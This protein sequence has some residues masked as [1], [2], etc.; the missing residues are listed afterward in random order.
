MS[1]K[2]RAFDRQLSREDHQDV[3]DN[4]DSSWNTPGRIKREEKLVLLDKI[5]RGVDEKKIRDALTPALM[6][7][8]QPSATPDLQKACALIVH[9][10]IAI[11]ELYENPREVRKVAPKLKESLLEGYALLV[12]LGFA[13]RPDSDNVAH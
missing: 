1:A 5:L 13:T 3:L 7:L 11:R 6:K 4:P 9:S 8:G 10:Q 2:D 12:E